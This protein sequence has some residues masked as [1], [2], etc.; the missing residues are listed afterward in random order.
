[1]LEVDATFLKGKSSSMYICVLVVRVP[2]TF[3]SNPSGDQVV[4]RSRPFT[5]SILGNG[6]GKGLG[7][8]VLMT[9]SSARFWR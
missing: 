3:V 4:W 5:S 1:M 8:V 6:G 2:L 7:T 9:S